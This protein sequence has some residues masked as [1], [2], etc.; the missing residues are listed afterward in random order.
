MDT[1]ATPTR[2]PLP[3]HRC[4]HRQLRDGYHRRALQRQGRSRLLDAPA[5]P[6]SGDVSTGAGAANAVAG[7][8]VVGYGR[9]FHAGLNALSPRWY[10]EAALQQPIIIDLP[11]GTLA[12]GARAVIGATQCPTLQL[13]IDADAADRPLP[14]LHFYGIDA[15]Q[16][17]QYLAEAANVLYSDWQGKVFLQTAIAQ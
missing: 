4:P 2:R 13:N 6:E 7:G 11:A 17:C 9:A 14:A 3:R 15:G 16:A 10:A 12:A 5:R 8:I 1:F